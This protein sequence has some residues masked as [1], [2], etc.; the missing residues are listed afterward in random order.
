[1]LWQAVSTIPFPVDH[2]SIWAR[3]CPKAGHVCTSTVSLR[4]LEANKRWN[5]L[6][7]SLSAQREHGRHK[8]QERLRGPDPGPGNVSK[9]FSAAVSILVENVQ[10]VW[11]QWLTYDREKC[12]KKN[13]TGWEERAS[14]WKI[15]EY[16]KEK[17]QGSVLFSQMN[18]SASYLKH[19]IAILLNGTFTCNVELCEPWAGAENI[20]W[21][22][23]YSWLR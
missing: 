12:T 16:W 8:K 21:F 23:L 19:S 18:F 17:W 10:N 11:A 22:K 7:A 9:A 4:Q 5:A 1:M 13:H 15:T 2:L 3:E 20:H 14:P 6:R